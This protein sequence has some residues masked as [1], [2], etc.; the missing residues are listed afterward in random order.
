[1]RC[2]PGSPGLVLEVRRVDLDVALPL[3]R[4]LVL[5]EAGVHRAGLDAGVA[6]DALLGVD[7]ELLDRVV[8][9]LV[10]SRV[11]A[12]DGADLD[13]GVVLLPDAGLCDY[14]R[15]ERANLAN[16]IRELIFRHGHHVPDASRTRQA[17]GREAGGGPGASPAGAVPD[18]A[19][20]GP[21][22]R[23]QPCVRPGR[24]GLPG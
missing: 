5:G 22:R 23:A 10:G 8:V 9:R 13:A 21:H 7:V 6:V 17:T 19:V 4:E 11:D 14:I 18:R 3:V 12:V 2:D 16:T 24:V 15:H 1:M 20:S